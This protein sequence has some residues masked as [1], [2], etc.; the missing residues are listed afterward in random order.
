MTVRSAGLTRVA[1]AL[2]MLASLPLA[3][4][5]VGG[6][7]YGYGGGYGGGYYD[8]GGYDGYDRGFGGGYFVGPYRGG[9]GGGFDRGRG[10]GGGRSIPGLPA[11]GR[12]GFHGGGG[13]GGFHGG[14]GGGGGHGR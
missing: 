3:G 12:G 2:G 14:G 7:D 11:G 10:V 5:A 9:G 8:V 6:P 13:G 1:L 4:C